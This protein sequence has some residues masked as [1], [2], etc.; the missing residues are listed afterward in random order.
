MS[1]RLTQGDENQ[2]QIEWQ[3]KKYGFRLCR[4]SWRTSGFR[5]AP[6]KVAGAKAQSFSSIFRPD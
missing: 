6:E 4:N 3:G 1:L 5:G 2:G